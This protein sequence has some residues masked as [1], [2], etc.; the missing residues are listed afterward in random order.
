MRC[1]NFDVVIL[2]DIFTYLHTHC[3]MI[4]TFKQINTST[5]LHSYLCV[6]SILLIPLSKWQM[7]NTL[8]STLVTT[9][10]P[11]LIHDLVASFYPFTAVSLIPLPFT[12]GNHTSMFSFC[13]GDIFRFQTSCS[14][15]LSL[16]GLFHLG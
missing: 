14:I 3:K 7:Y 13:G 4:T 16:S 15:C 2:T 10:S 9:G 1:F 6:L 11:G 5:T 12:P 8:L